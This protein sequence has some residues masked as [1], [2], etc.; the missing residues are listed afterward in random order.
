MIYYSLHYY[1]CTRAR[2]TSPTRGPFSL[3]LILGQTIRSKTFL[4]LL[5]TRACSPF[6]SLSSRL[7]ILLCRWR[8]QSARQQH[9]LFHL[10]PDSTDRFVFRQREILE[11]GMFPDVLRERVAVLIDDP[12]VFRGI[13]VTSTNVPGL[14]SLQ[15]R[16]DVE[17]VCAG[18]FGHASCKG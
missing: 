11:H 2:M 1:N 9:F 15:L 6:L 4:L 17:P 12:L 13:R 8:R 14:Q 3:S 7:F 10:V 5:S 16:I 18:E